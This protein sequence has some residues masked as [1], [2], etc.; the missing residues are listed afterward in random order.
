VKGVDI[1]NAIAFY[2]NFCKI[3]VIWNRIDRKGKLQPEIEQYMALVKLQTNQ[4]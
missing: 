1:T 3:R 4:I 2:R